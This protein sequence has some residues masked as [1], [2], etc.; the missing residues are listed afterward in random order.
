MTTTIHLQTQ[1]IINIGFTRDCHVLL[2]GMKTQLTLQIPLTMVLLSCDNGQGHTTHSRTIQ[3]LACPQVPRVML[4]PR[5]QIWH[6]LS[7]DTG[8]DINH[9]Y[10]SPVASIH[11]WTSQASCEPPAIMHTP[12]WTPTLTVNGC[13]RVRCLIGSDENTADYCDWNQRSTESRHFNSPTGKCPNSD[14]ASHTFVE[15]NFMR[16]GLEP[17][18]AFSH[19]LH[20][21]AGDES[22]SSSDSSG[23]WIPPWEYRI[24]RSS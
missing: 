18:D 5:V 2:D 20:D 9:G 13:S 22:S 11:F 10:A 15:R 3:C 12:S 19:H 24:V 21:H 1:W 16:Q 7:S 6:R 23:P 4:H 8:P 14:A 17:Q